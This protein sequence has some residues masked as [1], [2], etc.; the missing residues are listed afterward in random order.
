MADNSASQQSTVMP[1][2]LTSGLT[3]HFG[4]ITAV[5]DLNLQVPLGSIF[6]LL[7]P[8]G[9]GKTTTIKMLTT[10]LQPSAGT[11]RVAGFDVARS[12][13]Q[14][15]KA[16]GYVSQML[17][18][19]GGLTGYE[20]LLLFARIYGIPQRERKARSL[21]ALDFMGLSEAG[22]VLVRNYSGGMIRRLEIAQSMLHRPQV[23]FLDEPTIGL[24]PLARHTVW[25]HLRDLR[26]RFGA[27]ILMT[28]HDMDEA[29]R[30]CE[31]IAIMHRARVVATGS[32]EALKAQVGPQAKLDDVFV[33]FAGGPIDDGAGY[34]ESAQVRRTAR[35]LR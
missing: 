3:R 27:T 12:P 21:D 26:K 28:T 9:A 19:D 25:Q 16:I 15:R 10:M 33:H 32:P 1:A 35:R 11:A 6:G 18:A 23:L 20:N 34:R 17:S 30:L 14:V 4:S 24:D 22:E 13:V 5:D 31:Q 29:D 8:N 2:V 7:G